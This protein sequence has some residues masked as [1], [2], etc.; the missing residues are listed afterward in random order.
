MVLSLQ[1]QKSFKTAYRN[2]WLGNKKHL[3]IELIVN[4]ILDYLKK[5]LRNIV[6]T[7]MKQIYKVFCETSPLKLLNNSEYVRV[8]DIPQF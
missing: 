2:T 6:T 4:I 8:L 7:N 1:F 3:I 5:T